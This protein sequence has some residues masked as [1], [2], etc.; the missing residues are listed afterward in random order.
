[1]NIIEITIIIRNYVRKERYS[2]EFVDSKV[3]Q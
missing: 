3:V 1:M 2:E